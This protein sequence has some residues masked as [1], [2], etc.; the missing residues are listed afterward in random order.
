MYDTSGSYSVCYAA[1][2]DEN[3][4]RRLSWLGGEVARTRDRRSLKRAAEEERAMLLLNPLTTADAYAWFGTFLGLFPPFALFCRI[5]NGASEGASQRFNADALFLLCLFFLAMNAV[6]CLVGRKFAAHLGRKVGDPRRW[7]W[8][9]FLFSTLLMASAW[10]VV[11]GGVGGALGIGFGAFFGIICA[12][13]V[14]L[15]A[16]PIFASLHRL[17]SHGG[18]I[19]ERQLWPLAFGVPLVAAALILSPWIN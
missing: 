7:S 3:L 2:P 15:A 16:F 17:L 11:T 14:A 13:P 5:I 12:V 4:S 6:C 8:P 9:M 19:E 10:G 1:P 18:M